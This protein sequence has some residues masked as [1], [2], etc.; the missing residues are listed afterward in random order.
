MKWPKS[1]TNN[2]FVLNGFQQLQQILK[3]PPHSHSWSSSTSSH[4]NQR[5]Q[6]TSFTTVSLDRQITPAPHQLG[7]VCTNT[8]RISPHCYFRIVIQHLWEWF[9]N[10]ATSR[11]SSKQEEA[12]IPV[13][14]MQLPLANA[15]CSVQHA[16]TPL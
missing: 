6:H 12:M 2:S 11:C 1:I 5:Y 4:L 8:S 16:L 7:Y 13:A 15:L 10:G 3:L 9:V 14:W